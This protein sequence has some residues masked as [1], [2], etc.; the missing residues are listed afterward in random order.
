MHNILGYS[1]FF[2]YLCTLFKRGRVLRKKRCPTQMRVVA[3][4]FPATCQSVGHGDALSW[5]ICLNIHA[6]RGKTP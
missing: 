4:N 5:G 2:E 6:I 1:Y 3:I